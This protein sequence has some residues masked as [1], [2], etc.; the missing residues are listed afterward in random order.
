MSASLTSVFEFVSASAA[1]SI[2]TMLWRSLNTAMCSAV[3]PFCA[4]R[5]AHSRATRGGLL[6][7][8]EESQ[9]TVRDLECVTGWHCNQQQ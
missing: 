2:P 3:N 1:S 8:K 5:T 4:K 6:G 7:R 9:K